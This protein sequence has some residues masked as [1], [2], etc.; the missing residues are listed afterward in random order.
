MNNVNREQTFFSSQYRHVRQC[1]K[2]ARFVAITWF[3]ALFFCC[4]WI[5]YF[6][7]LP[8]AERPDDPQLVFGIPAWAAWGLLVPWLLLVVVT[9]YFAAVVLKDDEPFEHMPSA[10]DDPS[11]HGLEE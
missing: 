1:L 5:G 2:E 10:A 8:P 4:G 3:S 9:W 11:D 7:Y 6:G